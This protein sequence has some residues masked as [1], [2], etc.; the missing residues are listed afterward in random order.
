[1]ASSQINK[2]ILELLVSIPVGHQVWLFMEKEKKIRDVHQKP[3]L[4]FL[5]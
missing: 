2:D 1:M 4:K 5:I 3:N